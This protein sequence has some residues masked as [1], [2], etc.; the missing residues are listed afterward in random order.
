MKKWTIEIMDIS[1]V[2]T[3]VRD[4]YAILG[5]PKTHI[6]EPL[7]KSLNKQNFKNFELVI[8]DSLFKYRD[9]SILEEA[10]FPINYVPP[11]ECIWFDM[12]M[13]HAAN[14]FNT[15]LIHSEGDLVVKIDDCMEIANENHLQ[16]L[17]ELY[18]KGFIPL[19]TY[20]YHYKGKPAI[21]RKN[22]LKEIFSL[23]NFTEFLKNHL[24]E[25]WSAELYQPGD[26]IKDTRLDQFAEQSKIFTHEWY[27]GVSSVPLKDALAVNGYDEAMD[28]NRGLEDID[29]GSRLEQYGV[30]PFLIDKDLMLI[31]HINDDFSKK[32]IKR[33]I[34]FRNGYPIYYLSKTKKRFKAN[35]HT[36]TDE[37]IEFIREQ[38]INPTIKDVGRTKTEKD[39]YDLEWFDFWVKNQRTFNLAEIRLN[40]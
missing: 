21:Y 1:I 15:G 3:T 38:T 32:V 24:L 8:V 30:A 34:Y 13:F 2:L 23:G 9:K 37:E 35:T 5:C 14:N 6:F 36:F 17:W 39:E 31:E 11:K 27:Y 18:N 26:L 7:I 29:F 4:D 20:I 33:R 40:V 19:Q 28:G 25:N 22:L 16:K 10:T 12:G